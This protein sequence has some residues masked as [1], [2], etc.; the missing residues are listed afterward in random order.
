MKERN[1]SI[2]KVN[3][4]LLS[5]KLKAALENEGIDANTHDFRQN[6]QLENAENSVEEAST[7]QSCSADYMIW[8]VKSLKFTL[9]N[10]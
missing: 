4:A 5:E 7:S 2:G 1:L 9:K 10:A 8:I 6:S 3:K